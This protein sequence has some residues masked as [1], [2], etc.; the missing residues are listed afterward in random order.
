MRST[1]YCC[2]YVSVVFKAV[3]KY[4]VKFSDAI[5]ILI[6]SFFVNYTNQLNCYSFFQVLVTI[7]YF[8][9]IDSNHLLGKEWVLIML[10]ISFHLYHR[11]VVITTIIPLVNAGEF[12]MVFSMKNCVV[13]S[14]KCSRSNS[15]P[16]VHLKTL[17]QV[18]VISCFLKAHLD[19]I[20]IFVPRFPIPFLFIY[21]SEFSYSVLILH[22]AWI[23][24]LIGYQIIFGEE[25][26]KA[27]EISLYIQG[28]SRL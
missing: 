20:L 17:P 23:T 27:H 8:I 7:Y 26:K 19:I 16:L 9:Y 22:V 6:L 21:M 10:W 1:W 14:R 3:C 24:S 4:C 2:Q 15:F 12:Y 11:Q 5:W 13:H 18:A 25:H 28:V